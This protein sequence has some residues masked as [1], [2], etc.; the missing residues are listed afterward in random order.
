VFHLYHS[1]TF[2]IQR[3]CRSLLYQ[4]LT[5]RHNAP[6]KSNSAPF[7]VKLAMG[8]PVPRSVDRVH[9]IPAALL[10]AT[11]DRARP[12]RKSAN[13]YVPASVGIHDVQ[14]PGSSVHDNGVG[15]GD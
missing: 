5:T 8:R 11:E 7:L 9:L 2:A 12:E 4:A 3:S 13:V 10:G 14:V 15:H 1:L 6:P